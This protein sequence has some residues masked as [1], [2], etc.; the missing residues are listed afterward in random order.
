MS[1][2]P[3]LGP[4]ACLVGCQPCSQKRSVICSRLQ[5]TLG[6]EDARLAYR[7]EEQGTCSTGDG[8]VAAVSV[9]GGHD[10]AEVA[11]A[12]SAAMVVTV[13]TAPAVERSPVRRPRAVGRLGPGGCVGG[14]TVQCRSGLIR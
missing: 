9:T 5:S 3:A 4:R 11:A 8:A 1:A 14:R 13:I 12:G 6:G 10:K 7:V 2:S